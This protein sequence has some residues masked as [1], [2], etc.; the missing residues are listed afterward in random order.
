MAAK[1]TFQIKIMKHRHKVARDAAYILLLIAV[2]LPLFKSF[3]P[4][5]PMVALAALA[6]CGAIIVGFV[7]E[8]H[9]MLATLTKKPL[10]TTFSSLSVASPNIESA[11]ENY[12][13]RVS[14]PRVQVIGIVLQYQWPILEAYL[15][16]ILSEP[17]SRKLENLEMQIAL[18]DPDWPY[19]EALNSRF[20]NEARGNIERIRAFVSNNQ[21]LIHD[22]S[23]SFDIFTFQYIP[24]WVGMLIGDDVLFLCRSYWDNKRLRGGPNMVE[25][26]TAGASPL[27]SEI[28]KE[29][30]GWFRYSQQKKESV[31]IKLGGGLNTG[32]RG[33][34]HQELS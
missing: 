15:Q 3:F 34:D 9:S 1:E 17:Y 6:A 12:I 2:L 5:S 8:I 4:S 33:L 25:M 21:K 14:K 29:F 22:Y 24:H 32:S 16:R 13:Q 7:F 26:I 10:P 31:R 18:L 19:T 30:R 28:I 23:W 27:E 11:L 20:P